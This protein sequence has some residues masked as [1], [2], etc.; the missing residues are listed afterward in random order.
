MKLVRKIGAIICLMLAVWFLL[1]LCIGIVHIGVFYPAVILL[2]FAVLLWFWER[3]KPLLVR[4]KVWTSLVCGLLVVALTVILVPVAMMV[5]A[6]GKTDSPDDTTVI[7]LGCL[8]VGETPSLTLATR[9][10]KA[11]AY[12]N[13]N[14]NAKCVATGGVGN[15]AT[16]SEAQAIYN[17]LTEHGIAADR[18]WLEEQSTNTGEN[19][20]YSAEII[21]AN[22]LSQDVAIVSDDFHQWRGAYFAKKNDLTPY[23]IGCS[24]RWTIAPGY[25][26]REVAAVYKALLLGT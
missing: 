7:V 19:L 9:C 8:V 25:W 18:I 6:T 20:A 14:P 10:E 22:G 5:T 15:R 12:L 1:P 24:T 23:A 2:G 13:A 17:Y 3:V 16:I 11:V 21:R 4:H 26:A